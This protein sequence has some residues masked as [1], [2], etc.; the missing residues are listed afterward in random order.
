LWSCEYLIF[1]QPRKLLARK[2]SKEELGKK[3]RRKI[4]EGVVDQRVRGPV[5][6]IRTKPEIVCIGEKL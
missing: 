6:R 2:G 4:V 1:S 5:E 3:V